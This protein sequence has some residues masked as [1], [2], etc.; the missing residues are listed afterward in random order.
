MNFRGGRF[1][2]SSTWKIIG[3]S[4]V[5]SSRPTDLE[6]IG[7]SPTVNLVASLLDSNPRDV[8]REVLAKRLMRVPRATCFDAQPASWLGPTPARVWRIIAT[9]IFVRREAGP[10]R[11]TR[12]R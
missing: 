10:F 1:R 3:N 6:A 9:V 7:R 4:S 2:Y 5:L 8:A 11:E 12:R